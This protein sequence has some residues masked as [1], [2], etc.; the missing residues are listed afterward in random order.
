VIERGVS[1]NIPAPFFSTEGR[2]FFNRLIPLVL[3][4]R[5]T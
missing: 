2:G 3:D 1:R 4:Y 5:L